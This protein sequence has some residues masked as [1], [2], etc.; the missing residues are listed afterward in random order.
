MGIV[1]GGN[2]GIFALSTSVPLSMR[3]LNQTISILSPSIVSSRIVYD[4]RLMK[5]GRYFT[6]YQAAPV[7]YVFLSLLMILAGYV[8]YLKHEIKNN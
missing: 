3:V 2:F 8:I 6:E 4:F 5:L 1:I 7:I